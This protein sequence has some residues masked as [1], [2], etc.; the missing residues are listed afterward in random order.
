MRQEPV[1]D[2][3]LIED[4]DGTGMQSPGPLSDQ[5][6]IGAPL[7]DHHVHARQRQLT[8]QHQACR[9]SPCDNDRMLGFRNRWHPHVKPPLF[10]EFS[11]QP[12]ILRHIGGLAASPLVRYTLKVREIVFLARGSGT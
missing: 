10:S 11:L 6:L 3:A 8:R 9:T 4:L 5:V 1:G 7:D 12:T 2:P